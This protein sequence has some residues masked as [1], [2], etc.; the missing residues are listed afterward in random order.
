MKKALVIG[1]DDYPS[2]PLSC[3]L[4]DAQAVKKLLQQNFDNSPNFEVSP[5][6]TVTSKAE[7]VCNIRKLFD[8][9]GDLALF[10]FSGHGGVFSGEEYLVTPDCKKG[11]EGITLDSIVK[12]ANESRITNRIIILDCCHA[13][14]AVVTRPFSAGAPSF[15]SGVTVLCA[16]TETESAIEDG[17]HGLFTRLMLAALNG[18]AASIDG[19]V[20]PIGIYAYIDRMLGAWDQRPLLAANVS[21]RVVLRKAKPSIDVEV[22]RKLCDYFHDVDDEFSLD[23]SY[24]FTNSPDYANQPIVEPYANDRNVAI[25]KDLQKLERSGLVV[26]IGADHMYFAAIESKSCKLTPIGR[27]FWNL[28]SKRKI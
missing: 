12:I 27:F 15:A 28:A 1:I 26:P 8:G 18:G 17:E 6:E 22:L 11:D 21:S 3:C 20:S 25:F 24:E 16:C 9:I 13:G 10:Y 5:V 7:L 4:K 2:A 19:E 14:G 23:P